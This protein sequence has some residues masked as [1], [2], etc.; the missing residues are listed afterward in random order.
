MFLEETMKQTQLP[1]GM[2]FQ[3]LAQQP[4]PNTITPYYNHKEG[5]SYIIDSNGESIPF[6][7]W[8]TLNLATKTGTNTKNLSDTPDTDISDD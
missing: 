7:K 6:I 1:F 4:E 2:L 3:E 5:I 8:N